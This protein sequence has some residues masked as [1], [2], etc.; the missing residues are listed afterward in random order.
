[1]SELSTRATWN[2][3]KFTAQQ[4]N[5]T[6]VM[7]VGSNAPEI[8]LEISRDNGT[9]WLAWDLTTTLTMPSVGS[10]ICVRAGAGGN[11]F[12]SKN[13]WVGNINSTNTFGMTGKIAASGDIMSLLD[14]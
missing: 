3:L 10:T 5:S 11:E 4:A 7:L 1:M 13:Q 14:G 8:T 12:F 9:T 6:I 2:G